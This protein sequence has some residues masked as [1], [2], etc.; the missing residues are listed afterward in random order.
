MKGLLA[1]TVSVVILC[2]FGCASR[3]ADAHERE[4]NKNEHETRP[5]APAKADIAAF[6]VPNSQPAP[7]TEQKTARQET[8]NDCR[9]FGG[10]PCGSLAD[11]TQA[12]TTFGAAVIAILSLRH[13]AAQ[14]KTSNQQML[15]SLRARVGV[16]HIK[17]DGIP[18]KP[19]VHLRARNWFGK[20]ATLLGYWA[21]V[22]IGPLPDPPEFKDIDMTRLSEPLIQ[23]D[24]TRLLNK[25][26]NPITPTEWAQVKS[27]VVTCHAIG[28]IRYSD[29]FGNQRFSRFIRKYNPTGSPVWEKTYAPGY[30]DAD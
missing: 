30:N 29:G 9:I 27:G 25:T 15:L 4:P 26:L 5:A 19:V 10:M 21:D 13:L 22:R 20:P 6:S 16:T 28:Q 18:S 11:W 12:L 8:L 24:G 1:V 14:S 7:N 17:I 2:A 23:G 3:H